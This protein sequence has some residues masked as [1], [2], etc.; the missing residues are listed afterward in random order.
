MVAASG[1]AASRITVA[2]TLGASFWTC[3]TF[4]A[5]SVLSA[6]VAFKRAD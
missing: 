5:I 6:H 1:R 2:V 3:R 4:A